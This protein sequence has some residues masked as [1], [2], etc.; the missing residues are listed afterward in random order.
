[1]AESG[2]GNMDS[3]IDDLLDDEPSVPASVPVNRTTAPS[4]GHM[5]PNPAQQAAG[6]PMPGHHAQ[7][8]ANRLP[9]QLPNTAGRPPATYGQL[10]PGAVPTYTDPRMGTPSAAPIHMG[11]GIAHGG[12]PSAAPKAPI[13]VKAGPVSVAPTGA[14]PL[15]VMPGAPGGGLQSMSGGGLQSLSTAGGMAPGPRMPAQGVPVQGHHMAS[16][17]PHSAPIPQ[18]VSSKAATAAAVPKPIPASAPAA[19]KQMVG[20]E[21]Q[22]RARNADGSIAMVKEE[23][24]DDEE[25]DLI[26]KDDRTR[27]DPIQ[28]GRGMSNGEIAMAFEKDANRRLVNH[29]AVRIKVEAVCKENDI[30]VESKVA[31]TIALALHRRIEEALKEMINFSKRRMDV[32]GESSTSGE[33]VIGADS[34]TRVVRSSNARH[35]LNEQEKRKQEAREARVAAKKAAESGQALTDASTKLRE[36]EEMAETVLG[37]IGGRRKNANIDAMMAGVEPT[38]SGHGNASGALSMATLSAP[39]NAAASAGVSIKDRKRRVTLGDAL[40]FLRTDDHLKTS[41]LTL[42]A[43]AGVKLPDSAV[44]TA[45]QAASSTQGRPPTIITRSA[46]TQPPSATNANGTVYSNKYPANPLQVTPT[47]INQPKVPMPTTTQM[48]PAVPQAGG[49]ATFQPTTHTRPMPGNQ[50]TAPGMLV[51]KGPSMAPSMPPTRK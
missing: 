20:A 36:N 2:H 1:M 46:A 23:N 51:N 40:T 41:Q 11:P 37:F 49:L 9:V 28:H 33:S 14:V 4:H 24:N 21:G 34:T 43:M 35:Y 7:A 50:P 44:F 19:K 6:R 27:S 38:A 42:N 29:T 45:S 12:V 25:E 26:P 5:M 39:G 8:G 30:G 15:R 47:A 22:A 18:T 32:E 10:Q 16:S 48:R 13:T 17:V 31:E 3:F